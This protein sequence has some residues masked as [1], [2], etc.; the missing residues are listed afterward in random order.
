MAHNRSLRPAL[1]ALARE[2]ASALQTL[3]N[4]KGIK[5]R[6]KRAKKTLRQNKPAQDVFRSCAVGPARSDAA[7]PAQSSGDH[8][9]R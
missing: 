5:A 4:R 9:C 8:R 3:D 6:A 2:L 7:A 1:L